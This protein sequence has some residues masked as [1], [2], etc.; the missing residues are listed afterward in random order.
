MFMADQVPAIVVPRW[1]RRAIGPALALTTMVGATL[2]LAASEVTATWGG[3]NADWTSPEWAFSVPVAVAYPDNGGGDFFTAR[4]DDGGSGSSLVVLDTDI[5]VDR[6]EVSVDDVLQLANDR[7]LRFT[8]A[9]GRIGSGEL[10][11][12]GGHVVG[13]G[14]L[15]GAGGGAGTLHV[16]NRGGT[17]TASGGVLEINP[18]G[19]PGTTSPLALDNT[20]DI[21]ALGPGSTLLVRN[22]AVEQAPGGIVRTRVGGNVVLEDSL[23]AG[24]TVRVEPCGTPLVCG[25]LLLNRGSVVEGTR[26]IVG[27]NGVV[28]VLASAFPGGTLPA[29]MAVQGGRILVEAGPINPVVLTL[30]AGANPAG[31]TIDFG[32]PDVA[33]PGAIVM[34]WVSGLPVEGASA[35]R[36]AEGD[37]VLANSNG[38]PLAPR[39][40]IFLNGATPE[41]SQI[42]ADQAGRTLTVGPD[43]VLTTLPG[44][45]GRVGAVPVGFPVIGPAAPIVLAVGASPG[46]GQVAANIGSRLEIA[47]LRNEGGVVQALAGG[48]LALGNAVFPNRG[49]VHVL[50]GGTL[51]LDGEYQQLAESTLVDGL[52]R[53]GGDYLNLDGLTTVAAGGTMTVGG[54][55]RQDATA[56]VDGTLRAEG[57]LVQTDGA[58]AVGSLGAL[59]T[60]LLTLQAGRFDGAILGDLLL[61]GTWEL[62][63]RDRFDFDVLDVLDDGDTATVEGFAINT[64]A[65]AIAVD[66]GFDAAVGDFFDVLLAD[67]LALDLGQLA[68]SD[69]FVDA[70]FLVASVVDFFD[71]GRGVARQL[72]RLEVAVPEPDTLAMMLVALV[73]LAT[74]AR[75][76]PVAVAEVTG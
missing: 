33:N 35:I 14:L 61:D 30:D 56:T 7:A 36:V 22:A 63:I 27:E 52:A 57:G 54:E 74:G 65:G 12:D 8:S 66:L 64:P 11:N 70:R 32:G 62:Q 59:H 76:D 69:P 13:R 19:E 72:L 50:A 71:A 10:V 31:D 58:T 17:I 5:E 43:T 24:G 23:V 25:E 42:F 46:G 28:R 60:P 75:R 41:A 15:A 26:T 2:P 68:I 29:E 49:E 48:T 16:E 40:G 38:G 6:V 67:A 51:D 21:A 3:A 73:L 45:H 55:F 37:V 4:I 20:G 9:P 47:E 53:I 39:G 18:S 44:R 1:I 34:N